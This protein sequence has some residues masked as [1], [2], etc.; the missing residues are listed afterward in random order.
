MWRPYFGY[1][2]SDTVT[3]KALTTKYRKKSVEKHPNKGGSSANFRQ[4]KKMYDAAVANLSSSSPP[5][6]VIAP[7]PSRLGS[8]P[9]PRPGPTFDPHAG[10]WNIIG[11]H[12]GYN[13]LIRASAAS[14]EARRGL[15]PHIRARTKH[16]KTAFR[17]ATD[18]TVRPLV[19]ALKRPRGPQNA[20]HDMERHVMLGRHI[21]W[22]Y[23][24]GGTDVWD[25]DEVFVTWAP[26]NDWP[27]HSFK[28]ASWFG[29]HAKYYT[30]PARRAPYRGEA[31][32]F[33]LVKAAFKQAYGI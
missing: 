3:L 28:M 22:V 25:R 4:L 27:L 21:V 16:M 14:K 23:H 33:R 26:D 8:R 15:N 2:P 19:A 11:G 17:S 6:R 29:D 10:M 31:T 18:I 20:H 32:V 12:M 5:P 30:R 13:N 7:P 24:Y 1:G 9:R